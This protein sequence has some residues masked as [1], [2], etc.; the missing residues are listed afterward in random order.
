[1]NKGEQA[2]IAFLEVLR[3]Q[4]AEGQPPIYGLDIIKMAR[5]VPVPLTTGQKIGNTLLKL[6]GRPSLKPRYR[7][8]MY[9]TFARLERKGLIESEWEPE[10]DRQ[11]VYRLAEHDDSIQE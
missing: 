8:G 2:E 3:Q 4:A 9:S 10:T 5:E 11:R 7:A 1:M 6:A